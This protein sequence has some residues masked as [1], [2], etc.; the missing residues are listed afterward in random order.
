MS[1]G[2]GQGAVGGMHAVGQPERTLDFTDTLPVMQTEFKGM[3]TCKWSLVEIKLLR[4]R[5]TYTVEKQNILTF[6]H[7]FPG[8]SWIV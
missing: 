5:E 4:D 7:G 3:G 2:R 8:V 6:I 1:R